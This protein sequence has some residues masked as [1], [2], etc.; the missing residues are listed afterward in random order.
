[1]IR[2]LILFLFA[3]VTVFAQSDLPPNNY[4]T[5]KNQCYWKSR[6]PFADYWQQDVHYHIVAN[7]DEKT[8]IVTAT[9]KLTYWNNSPANSC[10]CI[11]TPNCLSRRRKT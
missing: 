3:Y 7:I 9:Q 4:A 10:S 5:T 1:M 8:D 2:L 11:P 6:K